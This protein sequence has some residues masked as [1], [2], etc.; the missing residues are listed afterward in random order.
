MNNGFKPVLGVAVE[1]WLLLFPLLVLAGFSWTHDQPAIALLVAGPLV[2]LAQVFREGNCA[3]PPRPL[4]VVAPVDGVIERIDDVDDEVLKRPARRIRIKVAVLG[5][6]SIR[7]PSEGMVCAPPSRMGGCPTSWLRTDEQD[8]VVLVVAEGSLLGTVPV[9]I[10]YGHRVG[11]GQRCGA[12]RLARRVDVYL[13]VGTRLEVAVGQAVKSGQD[14]I[15][16]L[17]ARN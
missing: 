17:M 1:G 9:R 11:Q 10:P 4:G 14:V 8:S 6:Y 7:A 2:F 16:T 12:R 13:P 5:A 15:A 3:V